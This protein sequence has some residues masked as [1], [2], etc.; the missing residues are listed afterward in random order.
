MIEP[1]PNSRNLGQ[2]GRGSRGKWPGTECLTDFSPKENVEGSI[3][4][5]IGQTSPVRAFKEDRFPTRGLS[6]FSLPLFR[7]SNASEHPQV[8]SEHT[9]RDGVFFVLKALAA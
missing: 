7:Q 2:E 1:V 9:P 5:E 6:R 4:A 8:V 3:S